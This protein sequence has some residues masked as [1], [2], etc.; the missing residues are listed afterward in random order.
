MKSCSRVIL[1]CHLLL[2][3]YFNSKGLFIVLV[4]LVQLTVQQ[5]RSFWDTLDIFMERKRNFKLHCIR[6]WL[7]ISFLSI[8]V[9]EKLY[10]MY[11]KCKQTNPPFFKTFQCSE[12][13]VN[14]SSLRINP[15]PWSM[16]QVKLNSNKWK[17][18]KNLLK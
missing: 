5:T 13:F 11:T 3:S 8:F 17:L 2:N 18:W 15:L 7:Y 14:T 9:R 10:T 4:L 1:I 16:G 6:C 12:C